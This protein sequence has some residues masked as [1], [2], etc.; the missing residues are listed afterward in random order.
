[1]TGAWPIQKTRPH[2]WGSYAVVHDDWKLL[3]NRDSSYVELFNIAADPYEQTDLQAEQPKV[4]TR[5]LQ[6]LKDWQKSIPAEPSGA[7]F[8]KERAE[9]T[10]R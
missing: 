1:M 6:E 10:L 8:S 5:L 3:T 4:V 7:V 9:T 2:H